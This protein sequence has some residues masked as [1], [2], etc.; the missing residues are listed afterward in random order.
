MDT[1]NDIPKMTKLISLK[2]LGE[3]IPEHFQSDTELHVFLLLS[4]PIIDKIIYY[5]DVSC[6]LAILLFAILF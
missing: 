5:I 4:D 3:I 2:C 6:M 1:K